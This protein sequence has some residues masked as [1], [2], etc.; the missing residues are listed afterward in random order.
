LTC[1]HS[2]T[3]PVLVSM[4]RLQTICML[5]NQLGRGHITPITTT[6]DGF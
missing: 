6:E 3:Q 5:D 1:N 2:I 4:E